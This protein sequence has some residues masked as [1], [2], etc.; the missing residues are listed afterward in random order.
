VINSEGGTYLIYR[1]VSEGFKQILELT[2]T[3]NNVWIKVAKLRMDMAGATAGTKKKL[4][5]EFCNNTNIDESVDLGS[6]LGQWGASDSIK[7][8]L[9]ARGINIDCR[10][11]TITEMST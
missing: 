8:L 1:N 9:K 11:D 6:S 3:K 10:L 2:P 7:S 4:L 5:L